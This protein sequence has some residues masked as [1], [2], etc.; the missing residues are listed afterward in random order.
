MLKQPEPALH[1]TTRTELPRSYAMLGIAR[2]PSDDT[3]RN[4]FL[5]SGQADIEAFWRP[6]RR[7]LLLLLKGPLAR[8]SLDMD[9]TVFCREGKREGARKGFN[10]RPPS[11]R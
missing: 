6:L 2:F 8:F 5:R 7:G 1:K 10:P 3:I 11:T 4:F 9:S